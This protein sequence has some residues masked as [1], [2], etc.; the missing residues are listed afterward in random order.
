MPD[1]GLSDETMADMLTMREALAELET[2]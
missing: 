2:G 1:P